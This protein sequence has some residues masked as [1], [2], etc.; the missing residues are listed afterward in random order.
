MTR[1]CFDVTP[2]VSVV[3]ACVTQ[4]STQLMKTATVSLTYV[5]TTAAT[6]SVKPSATA[7]AAIMPTQ[8]T[9]VSG[10]S[11]AA[12]FMVPSV[13]STLPSQSSTVT[14]PK[15]AEPP[16]SALNKTFEKEHSSDS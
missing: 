4:M 6:T 3:Y 2:P 8:S 15:P 10:S 12:Q 13:Q 1:Y 9:L 16:S 5:P 14:K 7:T 11:S